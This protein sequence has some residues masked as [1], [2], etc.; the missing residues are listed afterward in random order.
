MAKGQVTEFDIEA[1]SDNLKR[2]WDKLSYGY[3]A[4][5]LKNGAFH[6]FYNPQ[7]LLTREIISDFIQ[8]RNED[9]N[10]SLEKRIFKPFSDFYQEHVNGFS[11]E[12]SLSIIS[13]AMAKFALV[14]GKF[15]NFRLSNRKISKIR[16][17]DV[18][19]GSGNYLSGLITSGLENYIDYTGVD[20]AEK[21]IKLA[22]E[23]YPDADFAVG[24]ILGLDFSDKS[25]DAVLVSHVFE[26]IDTRYLE[27]AF[28]EILRVAKGI[29]ILNFFHEKDISNHI[30]F[31]D[32]DGYKNCLSR[33]AIRGFFKDCRMIRVI[34]E[35]PPG[36]GRKIAGIYDDSSV[37][38]STWIIE[39]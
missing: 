34:D 11:W 6:P 2:R 8:N 32:R 21:N 27:K 9:L 35:Y 12:R 24:N 18:G 19:C 36:S 13:G 26:H 38:L 28:S 15:R 14:L 20:I 1:E 17:L 29:V 7:Q 3:L 37:A 31:R 4:R 5:Y 25:F 39:K 23:L 30:I 33:K 16:L 10:F 22:V